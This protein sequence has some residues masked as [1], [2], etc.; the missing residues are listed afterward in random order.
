[1]RSDGGDAFYQ[2]LTALWQHFVDTGEILP[3]VRPEIAES[4]RRSRACGVDI[5][6]PAVSTLSEEDF[7]RLCEENRSLI[8]FVMPVM[9]RIHAL[10]SGTKNLISLHTPEGYML[11]CCGDEY[12]HSAQG[13]SSFRIGV[14]WDEESIGTNGV[15]LA[16]RLRR[17]VQVYGAEHY[18]RFQQDGTCSAA[19]IFGEDGTVL[20][21]INMAGKHT[22]GSLHTLGLVALGAF[23]VEKQLGLAHSYRLLDDTFATICE[24]LMVLDQDL[25][26]SRVSRSFTQMFRVKEERLLKTPFLELLS[27]PEPELEQELRRS[28]RPLSYPEMELDIFGTHVSCNI[29][30]TPTRIND[31]FRGALLLIRESKAVNSLVNHLAGNTAHYTFDSIITQDKTV[32]QAM[33]IMKSVAST[34]CT[35]LLEGESGTGKELFAHAIHSVSHRKNG[36]FIAVN[37][38]SLP[39]SLV[40]SELFGYE[41]G[42]FSGALGQGN[43]GKFELA[44]GGT[45]FLDEV[46]ELPLEIQAKLLRVLDT[47]RAYRLGGKREK[48]LNIRVIAA[49]NRNLALEIQ[50]FNFRADLYYRLNVLSF[51]IPPLRERTGDAALLAEY[52]LQELNRKNLQESRNFYKEF[53]K[54]F[55]ER[56]R[57]YSWPG[58]VRELQNV[59]LRAYY[60]SGGEPVIEAK[61][62]PEALRPQAEPV[63]EG[64]GS[65]EYERMARLMARCHGSTELAA[66]ELGMSRATCYRKLKELGIQPKAY[67]R[68]PGSRE[69]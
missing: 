44:D 57:A 22:T 68:R 52:F 37:C 38:A 4:W 27:A 6:H 24:G 30:C 32:L 34:D 3:E 21:V 60:C 55:L 19:P 40:E 63:L 29:S 14:K 20:G 10:V 59:V 64:G 12:Y 53:S 17:P 48:T 69:E 23:S 28:L 39:H 15:T 2:R 11:A 51:Y 47:H 13:A 18:C 1:M 62:L 16:L 54:E 43:P 46:G 58:N 65:E 35:V 61:Y 50:N 9:K 56:I 36:P 66:Q 41:K 49:T 25:C 31:Q 5:E 45:I 42:A 67:R 33:E 7:R 26:V 8:G